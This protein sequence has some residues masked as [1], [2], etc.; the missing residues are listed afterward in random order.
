[1][2][3][4]PPEPN[5]YLSCTPIDPCG[6]G[7][8]EEWECYGTV[9]P[10]PGVDSGSEPTPPPVEEC[11]LTCV[12]DLC[13]PGTIEQTVCAGAVPGDDPSEPESMPEEPPIVEECWTECI[14]DM[15][16]PAGQ[17]PEEVCTYCMEPT[18][19]IICVDDYVSEPTEPQA[20]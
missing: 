4:I 16:C 20:S 18:C 9:E 10:Q 17:H 2:D 14:P 12:P 8:H 19:E 1:V 6:E 5:C 7:F 13:P 11:F 15:V 3:C